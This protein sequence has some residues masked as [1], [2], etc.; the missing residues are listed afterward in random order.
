MEIFLGLPIAP[1]GMTSKD[2][3]DDDDVDHSDNDDVD[4]DDHDLISSAYLNTS[5]TRVY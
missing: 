4:D 3:D 5:T 2:G 1:K